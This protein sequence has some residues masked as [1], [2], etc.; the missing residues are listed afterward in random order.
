MRLV[1]FLPFGVQ[2]FIGRRLGDLMYAASSG[3]REVARIN[4]EL[5]FPELDEAA[6]HDLVRETFR[7]VGI[8]LMETAFA[9]WGSDA[10]LDRIS[11]VEGMEHMNR[12][13]EQGKGVFLLG[14]HYT[15]L[16]MSGR[17]MCLFLEHVH[18]MYK[19]AS[20]KLFNAVMVHAR[21]QYFEGLVDNRDMRNILRALRNNKVIWYAPDQDFGRA[22]TVF[23]PFMGVDAVSLTMTARMAKMSGAPVLPFYSQ[24]LPG[25]QGYLMRVMPPLEN[26]PSDDDV[27]DCTKVNEAIE[28]QVRDAPEQYLWLHRRFKTRPKGEPPIYPEK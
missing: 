26:F 22:Q 10:R 2:L 1:V 4:L 11:R 14:G 18:P 13:L 27:A 19:P 21:S 5:C 3:H 6:R 7:S 8:T 12:A 16:E 24:R 23:A 17:L 28:R 9:W 20:N 15:T 25:T